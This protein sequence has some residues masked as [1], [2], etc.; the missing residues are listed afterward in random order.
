MENVLEII[1]QEKFTKGGL[2]PY[3]EIHYA[4][5]S[6]GLEKVKLIKHFGN[7]LTINNKIKEQTGIKPI[8]TIPLS[9][10]EELAESMAQ[11]GKWNGRVFEYPETWFI[12][13]RNMSRDF[14]IPVSK[15]ALAIFKRQEGVQLIYKLWSSGIF[16]IVRDDGYLISLLMFVVVF[17]L[18]FWIG[19][20]IFLLPVGFIVVRYFL[21]RIVE[22]NNQNFS[23][24]S[25]YDSFILLF[26][27][28]PGVVGLC[29][30]RDHCSC[31]KRIHRDYHNPS[32]VKAT[33]FFN[34]GMPTHFEQSLNRTWNSGLNP[35]ILSH[36]R[37]I[38]IVLTSALSEYP[39]ATQIVRPGEKTRERIDPVLYLIEE[40]D[41]I[42]YAACLDYYGPVE[43]QFIEKTKELYLNYF[44]GLHSRS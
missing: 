1:K 21:I 32:N 12:D 30:L 7:I 13:L 6:F 37:M 27:G 31:E 24:F 8:C 22:W 26:Q 36:Y 5:L 19:F 39:N 28:K 42:R 11:V 18:R 17:V 41:G 20:S 38:D 14:Q 3:E 16:R 10:F 35:C 15:D 4:P 33:V 29:K 44:L 43:E 2:T 23:A 25:F 34:E 40:V 9:V